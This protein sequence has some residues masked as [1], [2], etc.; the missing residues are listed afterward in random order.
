MA[1]LVAAGLAA[2]LAGAQSASAAVSS[3]YFAALPHTELYFE[4]TEAVAA[5]LPDGRVLIAGG[6]AATGEKSAEVFNPATGTSVPTEHELLTARIGAVAVALADG[7][8]LIAGGSGA[9]AEKSA[10][11]FNPATGEFTAAVGKLSVGRTGAVAASLPDGDV[12]IAGGSTS[13]ST[14]EV[15]EPEKGVVTVVDMLVSR[16]KA[17]AAALPEGDLLIA[18]GIGAAAEKSAEMFNPTTK[19]FTALAGAEQA[20]REGA[21]AVSLPDGEVLIAGGAGSGSERTAERFDPV[22]ETFAALPA[23]PP[24]TELRQGRAAAVV[25]PLANG[26]ML[27]A[28]GS[29]SSRAI[30]LFYSAPQATVAGGAF[31]DQAV[32]E[33]SAASVLVITNVG[34]QA[35]SLG[36]PSLS[37]SEFALAGESC[38]G[39]TLAFEQSCSIAV[40]FTPSATGPKEA[41]ITLP[42]NEPSGSATIALSGTGVV[43]DT[44]PKGETGSTGATGPTGPTGAT[45]ATG[46]TG[47]TGPTGPRGAAGAAGQVILVTCT[48]STRTVNHKPKK[49]TQCK[50]RAVPSPTTFTSDALARAT[51]GRHGFIY[52]TGT[53]SKGRV[54]LHARRAL[55]AGRYT[56]TLLSGHGGSALVRRMAVELP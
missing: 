23:S 13:P 40:R 16:E 43:A 28:G 19:A 3:P 44:G 34:A 55:S 25:A 5:P 8:V 14:A 45:G 24:N 18:G 51:L 21:V 12:L 53:A 52:A 38:A 31:G 2:M 54:V 27:I 29:G 4:R 11:V 26:Q 30:E 37:G 6:S 39:R 47:P 9:A 46:A 56:L 15:F 41:K 32:G 48:T 1:A 7:S 33:P 22:T 35:L 20:A 36:T 49:V 50:T 10:E 42:D 17:V